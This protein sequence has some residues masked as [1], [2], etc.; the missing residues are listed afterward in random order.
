MEKRLVYNGGSLTTYQ[1]RDFQLKMNDIIEE[2][3][4]NVYTP[5]KNKSINDKEAVGNKDIAKMI[6]AKDSEAIINSDIRMFNNSGTVGTS[7]E[8]GQVLG[9]NDF[10]NIIKKTI[11]QEETK[12]PEYEMTEEARL[13]GIIDHIWLLC[14]AELYKEF[15]LFD[16]DVRS[17]NEPEAGYKRSKGYHQYERGVGMRLMRNEEGYLR[18]EEQVIPKLDELGKASFDHSYKANVK[19]DDNDELQLG[20]EANV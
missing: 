9:M 15:I 4:L 13:Q 17:H 20:D 1:A 5:S 18:L 19:F 8:I 2:S 12:E 11:E 6:V 7:I 10:A 14:N 3:G 16:V